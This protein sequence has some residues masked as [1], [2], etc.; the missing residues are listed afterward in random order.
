MRPIE[1]HRYRNGADRFNA[2]E[3]R[4]SSGREA[5]AFW[6]SLIV[7]LSINKHT[8][9][10]DWPPVLSVVTRLAII[11]SIPSVWLVW[12]RWI[13]HRFPPAHYK[14]QQ[15]R[16]QAS[17]AIRTRPSSFKPTTLGSVTIRIYAIATL[18]LVIGMPALK[19]PGRLT[20][21]VWLLFGSTYIWITRFLRRPRQ[22]N[23]EDSATAIGDLSHDTRQARQ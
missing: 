14:D 8:A 5:V 22:V 1:T 16:T 23:P 2:T 15:K 7:A 17:R 20:L 21:P 9:S 10:L 4:S 3:C 11:A 6:L 13:R 18:A 12:H 19:L